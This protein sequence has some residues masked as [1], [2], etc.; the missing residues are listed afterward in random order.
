MSK[1]NFLSKVVGRDTS[2]KLA[3]KFF[4]ACPGFDAKAMQAHYLDQHPSAKIVPL[5]DL[6]SEL[7][8]TYYRKENSEEIVPDFE[9][10]F[11][12]AHV[13]YYRGMTNL[14]IFNFLQRNY[15]IRDPLLIRLSVLVGG[16]CFWS[17]QYLFG[18]NQVRFIKNFSE[19]AGLDA[20]PERGVVV[21]EAFHPRIKT[22]GGEFRFFMLLKDSDKGV[23][24]GVHSIP[25]PLGPYVNRDKFCYRA[26]IPR[27]RP[28]Y[29]CNFADPSQ[30]LDLNG[31]KNLFR[32]AKST[33][34]VKGSQGFCIIHDNDGMPTALWHDNCTGNMSDINVS[35]IAGTA[36]Q[37]CV[38]AFYVPDFQLNAPLINVNKNE[39]GFQV[40]SLLLKAYYESG[41]F[42]CEKKVTLNDDKTGFDLV[43]VFEGE[44]IEGRVY[45]VADFLRDQNEFSVRVPCY[46]NLYYRRGDLFA[47]QVHSQ[48]TY[49]Y[50]NDPR[51]TPKSY[52]CLKMAPL[53]K[54]FRNV[55]C[56]STVG[57]SEKNPDNTI[58]LRIFTDKETEH[59]FNNYPLAIGDGVSTIHGDDLMQEIGSYIDEAAIVWIEHQTTNFNGNWFA[60]DRKTGH[61]A[62]DHFTGA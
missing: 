2:E 50:K 61:L 10:P 48:F 31:G 60:I 32:E 8:S 42:I 44:S 41:E 3:V 36:A 59:V 11:V 28:A 23:L 13:P 15:G 7:L 16:R 58:T 21:L 9:T 14:L 53:F 25:S 33:D 51:A 37:P 1:L 55:Y 27:E 29:Y 38:T 39:I 12:S 4:K 24:S 20:L 40:K 45:F 52:R 17:R 18:P 5:S 57:G 46:L 35:P 34:P 43:K 30:V 62:T 19:E 54:E 6:L 56:L 49:G 47:D 22:P 26:Y